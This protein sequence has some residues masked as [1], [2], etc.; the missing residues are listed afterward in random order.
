M[1]DLI[2][3]LEQGD[4]VKIGDVIWE[5]EFRGS[6]R[7]EVE[8]HG[9]ELYRLHGGAP[10]RRSR[11][12]WHEFGRPFHRHHHRPPGRMRLRQSSRRWASGSRIATEVDN[13]GLKIRVEERA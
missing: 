12:R 11:V 2:P 9:F 13:E 7:A 8:H 10:E 1:M 6:K 5:I 4:L 3:A